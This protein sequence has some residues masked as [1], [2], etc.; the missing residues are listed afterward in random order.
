[1]R[2]QQLC[3]WPGQDRLQGWLAIWERQ[4]PPC[5]PHGYQRRP[6]DTRPNDGRHIRRAVKQP[7]VHAW[8]NRLPNTMVQICHDGRFR[9]TKAFHPLQPTW[10]GMGHGVVCTSSSA[11]VD[12][13]CC[14]CCCFCG[15]MVACCCCEQVN[16]VRVHRCGQ[17][18]SSYDMHVP[19]HHPCILVPLMSTR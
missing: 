10:A 13:C 4:Q 5:H 2:Q 19:Q 8:D 6:A 14:C 3:L 18:T 1:M 11:P 12:F 17:A 15:C 16:D 7:E 9:K